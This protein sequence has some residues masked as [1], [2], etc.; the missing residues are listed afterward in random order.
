[1]GEERKQCYYLAMEEKT[2]YVKL[3]TVYGPAEAEIIK[4]KLEAEG[5]EVFLKADSLRGLYGI[6]LDGLGK[7]E[8][9]VKEEDKESAE[10]LLAQPS[11]ENKEG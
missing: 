5:I 8:I 3:T 11:S 1:L 10:T 4:A 6:H 7:V 9:W 2:G